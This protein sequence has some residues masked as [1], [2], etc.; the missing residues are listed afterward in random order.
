MPFDRTAVLRLAEKLYG[1][2]KFDQAIAEYVR[3]LEDHPQDWSTANTLGDV[4]VRAGY[5]EQGIAYYARV[6]DKLYQDGFRPKAAALYRKIL[7]HQ[8]ANQHALLQSAEISAAAGLLAD[9]RAHFQALNRI[10]R[11]RG[12]AAAAARIA[13]RMAALDPDDDAARRAGARAR[14]ELGDAA[15][16]VAELKELATQLLEKGHG[17]RAIEALQDALA[18]DPAD[19]DAQVDLIVLMAASN[20]D[21]AFARVILVVEGCLQGS[22][23]RAAIA[24]L[25]RWLRVAPQH[26][27]ALSRLV[28]IAVDGDNE[29]A[30]DAAQGRLGDAYLLTGNLTAARH[31]AEDL[32]RRRPDSPEHRSR[33]RTALEQLGVADPEAAIAA[34]LAPPLVAVPLDVEPIDVVPPPAPPVQEPVEEVRIDARIPEVVAAPPEEKRRVITPEARQ[35]SK[36]AEIDLTIVLEDIKKPK[37]D[38]PVAP[39]SPP[40]DLDTVFAQMREAAATR[41]MEAAA[42]QDFTRGIV[43]FDSGDIDAALPFLQR[44]VRTPRFRFEA[45]SAL[46]RAAR[47]RGE[48]QQSIQWMER[49]AEAPPTTP[50]AGHALLYELAE[51][52]ESVGEFTRALAIYLELHADAGDYL[53]VARRVDRLVKMQAN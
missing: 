50:D 25:E 3:V 39:P 41:S 34:A 33:L 20:R 29:D 23:S 46:G 38:I 27:P 42:E 19:T 53:D 18:I 1:L 30:I 44:A 12:D 43:L 32:L 49:A 7:K 51:L 2:G 28:E 48:I 37:L 21:E 10:H 13:I 14:V 17:A 5:I 15:A 6:A 47:R 36:V 40:A 22:D 26:I 35:R 31:I 24:A 9:A 16:A 8:P 4:C 11:E 52:L 45:A